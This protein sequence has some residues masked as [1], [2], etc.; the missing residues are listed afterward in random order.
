MS[1]MTKCRLMIQSTF[2]MNKKAFTIV[3]TIIAVM[4]VVFAA[5]AVIQMQSGG[6]KNIDRLN[7]RAENKYKLTFLLNDDNLQS[8][9]SRADFASYITSKYPIDNQKVADAI[10]NIEFIK[11][12]DETSVYLLD[13]MGS[14]AMRGFRKKIEI[15]GSS[16]AIYGFK[17]EKR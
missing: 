17:E 15:G 16:V 1:N 5:V 7:Q 4:I 9:G 13:A 11:S 10:K 12:E 2:L 3:E 8:I 14:N 6:I